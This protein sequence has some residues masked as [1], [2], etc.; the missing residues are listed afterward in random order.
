MS[1]EAIGFRRIRLMVGSS[2]EAEI[3]ANAL[4]QLGSAFEAELTGFFVDELTGASRLPV[5]NFVSFTGEALEIGPE[6]VERTLRREVSSCVRIFKTGLGGRT[7][8]WTSQASTG[9]A[10]GE[11]TG[12]EIIAVAPGRIV[13]GRLPTRSLSRAFAA[14]NAILLVPAARAAASGD[15]VL[16]STDAAPSAV[17]MALAHRV[18]AA[19]GVDVATRPVGSSVAQALSDASAGGLHIVELLPDEM[20]EGLIDRLMSRLRVPVL[21][22]KR[23]SAAKA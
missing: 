12:R 5:A 15:V 14:G 22:L 10:S 13:A 9:Q 4:R 17:A 11:E 1:G 19:T 20:D 21:L 7:V 18:A 6:E 16:S 23:A 8:R 3:L 2:G